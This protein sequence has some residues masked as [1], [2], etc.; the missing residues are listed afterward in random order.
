MNTIKLKISISMF[1]GYFMDMRQSVLKISVLSIVLLG[2]AVSFGMR[3]NYKGTLT[4]PGSKKHDYIGDL[5]PELEEKVIDSLDNP[6][7]FGQTNK[8]NHTLV[9]EQGQRNIC[10]AYQKKNPNFVLNRY[11]PILPVCSNITHNWV[12]RFDMISPYDVSF[13]RSEG[14][15]PELSIE[16]VSLGKKRLNQFVDQKKMQYGDHVYGSDGAKPFVV[17]TP[18]SLA[19]VLGSPTDITNEL[20]K[21]DKKLT[22]GC[23]YG[24]NPI[25]DAMYARISNPDIN[26]DNNAFELLL[27]DSRLLDLRD[28]SRGLQY[29]KLLNLSRQINNKQA[30]KYC[31]TQDV[32]NSKNIPWVNTYGCYEEKDLPEPK[33]ALDLVLEHNEH[34]SKHAVNNHFSDQDIALLRDNGAKRAQELSERG[35]SREMCI[36]S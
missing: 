11:V 12:Y 27:K 29:F 1:W 18:L 13:Y 35:P 17:N 10:L 4:I 20:N 9:K 32:H 31:V 3:C 16:I 7:T 2:N 36:I 28:K 8:K 5:S 22:D 34:C 6:I 19:A 24:S 26:S 25:C 21:I 15:G 33:T 30:F 23:F 14:E